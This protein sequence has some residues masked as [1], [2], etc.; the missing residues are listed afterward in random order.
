LSVVVEAHEGVA[1]ER[2]DLVSVDLGRDSAGPVDRQGQPNVASSGLAR[3]VARAAPLGF[4]D[5]RLEQHRRR[6]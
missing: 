1:G 2:P 3:G 5:R 6:S 4:R